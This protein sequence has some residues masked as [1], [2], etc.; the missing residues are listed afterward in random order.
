MIRNLCVFLYFWCVQMHEE[1]FYVRCYISHEFIVNYNSEGIELHSKQKNNRTNSN[2]VYT[3]C[4][5]WPLYLTFIMGT[6][7]AERNTKTCTQHHRRL[8]VVSRAIAVRRCVS[9]VQFY[10]YVHSAEQKK[11]NLLIERHT[12]S[13][14]S[15]WPREQSAV[16]WCH[17]YSIIAPF[18]PSIAYILTGSKNRNGNC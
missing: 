18:I 17:S 13:R 8:S 11:L 6:Q 9:S 7:N 2:K 5:C 4:C 16:S 15:S 14:K 3:F 1:N 12:I 10:R